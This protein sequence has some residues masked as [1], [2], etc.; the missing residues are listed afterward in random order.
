MCLATDIPKHSDFQKKK[1]TLN[2]Y[3]F[4]QTFGAPLTS[5]D[6]KVSISTGKSHKTLDTILGGNAEMYTCISE[7]LFRGKGSCNTS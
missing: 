2:G 1:S 6:S 5:Y 7:F 3:H 4:A